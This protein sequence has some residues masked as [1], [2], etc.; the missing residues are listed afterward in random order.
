M[1]SSCRIRRIFFCVQAMITFTYLLRCD[2]RKIK[3]WASYLKEGKAADSIVCKICILNTEGYITS[4]M[5]VFLVRI[6]FE[7]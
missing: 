6:M 4:G 5:Q 1:N 3:T 7:K 2:V